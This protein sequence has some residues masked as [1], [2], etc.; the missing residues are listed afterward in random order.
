MR[1]YPTGSRPEAPTRARSSWACR[2]GNAS[3]E[4]Q[5]TVMVK[6]LARSAGL[7]KVPTAHGLRHSAITE[8]LDRGW[9]VR[10]VK[11]FSRHKSIDTVLVYDDRRGDVGGRISEDLG[12]GSRARKG[13]FSGA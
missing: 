12:K 7:R 6:K 3:T 9:D 8:A 2:S 10:D 1:L 4:Q 5:L 11:A 13:P